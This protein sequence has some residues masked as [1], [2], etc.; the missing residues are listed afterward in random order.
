M[1]A[2]GRVG[3]NACYNRERE[4]FMPNTV[5]LTTIG[6]SIG[7]VLPK[8]LLTKLNV[9]KGDTLYVSETPDGIQLTPYDQE[10]ADQMKAA[11]QVMKENR[12]VLRRLAE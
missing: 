6:N 10:F 11:R 2:T 4:L 8:E 12:D 3:Y 7:I 5:K 9:E 1:A